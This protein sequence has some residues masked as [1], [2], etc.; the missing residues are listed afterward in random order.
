MAVTDVSICNSALAKVGAG[1]IN[2]LNDDTKTAR[3][4]LEQYPK[5]RDAA[6]KNHPW[7]FAIKRAELSKLVTTPAFGFDNEFQLPI[8]CLR[9]LNL[10]VEEFHPHGGFPHHSAI[11]NHSHGYKVEGRKLLTDLAEVKIRYIFAEDNAGNFDPEFAEYLAYKL[12]ADL[13]YPLVQSV[14]LTDRMLALA[15]RV[16]KDVR[17]S[18]AQEGTP[19]DLIANVWINSRI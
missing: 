9:V 10:D 1:R 8:D 12:A 19:D 7:N 3:L 16:L 13:A 15:D 4:C 14:S 5:L 6:L 11:G 2:T 17:S 18:D